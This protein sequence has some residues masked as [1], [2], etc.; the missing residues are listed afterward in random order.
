MRLQ[1]VLVGGNTAS[2]NEESSSEMNLG[3]RE[4]GFLMR[5]AIFLLGIFLF[6]SA[7]AAAQGPAG[8]GAPDGAGTGYSPASLQNGE[9]WQIEIG[10]QFNRD[11]LLGSPFNTNGVN[12]SVARY[13][14]TWFAAEAQLGAGFTHDT[15]GTT[16]PPNLVAKSLFVGAGPRVV[17]RNRSRYEPWAHVLVGLDHYRFTQSGGL[18]G[19]NSSF[20]LTP[21][22]GVDVY[23]TPSIAVRGEVDEVF[24]RF[25]GTNQ[26]S[27]QAVGGLVF[28]F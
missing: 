11:N 15:G 22:G 26:R 25:F 10:Y 6:L 20:G 27:F 19:S 1:I 7:S 21:G 2:Y 4:G 9:P 8:V 13:F 5:V 24:S 18:L 28:N 16:I 3:R 12:I 14:R 17:Y 23:L